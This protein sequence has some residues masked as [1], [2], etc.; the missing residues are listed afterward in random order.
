MEVFHCEAHPEQKIPLYV[1]PCQSPKRPV[2]TQ[3]CKK[4]SI[5]MLQH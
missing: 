5:K 3:V 2:E 4:V 1:G